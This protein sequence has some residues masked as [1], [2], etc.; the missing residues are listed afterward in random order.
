MPVKNGENFIE[1]ALLS[2]MEN[3]TVEDE[4]IIIDDGSTDGTQKLVGKFSKTSK[5]PVTLLQGSNLLPS[6]AR[7]QGLQI[8]KGKYISFIDHDDLW[9]KDRL[10]Y[11]INLLEKLSHIDA[12]Q[13]K[14]KYF[15]ATPNKLD[16]F[17]FLDEDNSVFFFQV[18]TYTF[19]SGIFKNIGMFDANLKFGED[20][21]LYSR[22]VENNIKILKDEKIA[23]LYRIHDNNMTN[24]YS[25][26]DDKVTFRILSES[27]K[28][29]KLK[30][31]LA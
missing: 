25:K 23:L 27:I 7:N 29:K 10:N 30:E 28:R 22:L 6:G 11:H 13:G 3:A 16:K 15:S 31:H 1:E 20:F 4:I 21:D 26:N 19:R 2:L 12:V 18:G 5:V 8:A 9:P 14:V 24:N 17:D